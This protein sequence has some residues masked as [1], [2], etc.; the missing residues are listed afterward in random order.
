[1]NLKKLKRRR[2]AET[3]LAKALV[4]VTGTAVF[5]MVATFA[6]MI[7]GTDAEMHR[8]I[9]GLLVCGAVGLAGYWIVRR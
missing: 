5:L 6:S 7:G 3:A 8:G 4:L 9:A 1:M 2:R